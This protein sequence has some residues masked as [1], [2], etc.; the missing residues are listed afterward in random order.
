MEKRPGKGLNSF[1]LLGR[2]VRKRHNKSISSR[3]LIVVFAG[4]N[5]DINERLQ[6]HAIMYSWETLSQMKAIEIVVN[7]IF[8]LA[9]FALFLAAVRHP[10]TAFIEVPRVIFRIFV[11]VVR[12][13]FFIDFFSER[14]QDLVAKKAGSQ[15]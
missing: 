2:K 4:G 10:H 3:A 14:L 13:V 12:Q 5:I 7:S 11:N 8:A 1:E 9:G 15:R 6:T